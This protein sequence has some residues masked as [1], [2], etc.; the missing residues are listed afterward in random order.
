MKLSLLLI[1]GLLRVMLRWRLALDL[2]AGVISAL[3]AELDV[4]LPM[5]LYLHLLDIYVKRCVIC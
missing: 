4:K 5:F 3:S 2:K 1:F